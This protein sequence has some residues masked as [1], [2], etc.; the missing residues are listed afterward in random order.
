MQVARAL[1]DTL[2]LYDADGNVRPNLV[3]KSEHNDDFTVW[4]TTL[5]PNI[6][7][8]NGKKVTAN[9]VIRDQEYFRTSPVLGGA[10][11]R[12][13]IDRSEIID[14]LTYRVFTKRPWP[15]MPHAGTTQL[16]VVAD[17][18][19]LTSPDWAHPIGTGPFKIESWNLGKNMVLTRNPDY[20]RTDQW[21]NHLPYLDKL[22]YQ[23][24]PSDQERAEA[25]AAGRVDV[26]MQTLATPAIAGMREQCKAGRL[27]CYSDEKGETPEDFVVLNTTKPP[28]NDVD[29]RRA[30]AL[31]VDR[32]DYVRRVTGGLVETADGMY[33]P[34]SPWYSPSA[35]PAYDPTTAKR[36][37]N[38]VKA[39]NKGVFRFELIAPA[40]EDAA[41]MTAY[42][43][44]AWKRVGIDVTVS[45]MDNQKKII[46]LVTGA[47]QA[48]LTQ[49]FDAAHPVVNIAFFDPDQNSGA[50]TL[51]FPRLSDP[52]LSSLVEMFLRLPPEMPQWRAVNAK[53][54]DR[55]NE[56]VPFI[57]LDH[58]PRTI[59]AR[60]NVVNVVRSTLPDGELAEDFLLGSHP[61][62]QIWI[63]RG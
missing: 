33:G 40:T 32:D 53:I 3:A 4:T 42:L 11:A 17:P 5:R 20:W 54:M 31:A 22:E 41:R 44:E 62:S 8:H 13:Y 19:W 34:S 36:L 23:V 1:F 46:N 24:I 26:M 57:W 50:L 2:Y 6:K 52:E 55:L 35:Y 29:A 16:A 12:T 49:Q 58:A 56:L 45:T 47:Y 59:L 14:E 27:Q 48:S 7:F 39:R 63:K 15:T 18:D 21:G 30:L 9:D 10:Y 38:G 61:V 25:L 37:V 43:Q 28:F 60:P 51:S